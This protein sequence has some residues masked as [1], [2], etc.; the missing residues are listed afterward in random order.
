MG[1]DISGN[2]NDWTVGG[3]MTQTIDTP[4][5]VFATWNTLGQLGENAFSNG[6]T[7]TPQTSSSSIIME[8][9]QH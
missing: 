9:L 7:N 2:N 6:N 3:T 5:N 8:Y 4:S 1:N